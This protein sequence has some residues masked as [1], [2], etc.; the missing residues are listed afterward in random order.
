MSHREGSLADGRLFFQTW[1]AADPRAEVVIAHGY[2]EHGGRYAHV[3]AALA[4]AGFDVWALDHRGHGR[5]TG[6]R[7]DIGSMEAVVADLDL[8]VDVAAA[9]GRPVF[10]LGH[11]MGGAIALAYAQAHQDRLAG[12]S[13]SGAAVVFGPEL[14]ALAGLEEIPELPLAD[15]VSTDPAVVAAYKADPLVY[16]GPPSRTTLGILAD[17]E[18][19]IAGLAELTLP[20][21]VMHGSADALIPS[22]ALGVIVSGVSSADVT[23][24]LWPG[25]FHEIYNEPIKEQVIGELISWLGA[26]VP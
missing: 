21:Q 1:Q 23:A 18:K 14:L 2:A 12:L 3:A 7:G 22:R 15:A 11:S 6:D 20:I 13:L 10:L 26:R 5:S 25:L 24:R 16:Q 9:E 4:A 8:L 17:S 19:L